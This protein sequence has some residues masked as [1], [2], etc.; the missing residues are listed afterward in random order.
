MTEFCKIYITTYTIAAFF[1]ICQKSVDPVGHEL[2]LRK[3]YHYFSIR[4]SLHRLFSSLS[5]RYHSSNILISS[6]TIEHHVFVLGCQK[7][8][9]EQLIIAIFLHEARKPTRMNAIMRLDI[10]R[11]SHA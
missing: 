6:Q 1:F 8:I 2:L 5:K 4:G 9:Y 3:L 11:S 10:K 7:L